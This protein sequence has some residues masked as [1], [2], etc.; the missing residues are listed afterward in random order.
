MNVVV[1][2]GVL[3]RAAEWRALPSGDTL[4]AYEVT[5]RDAEGRARTVPVAWPGGPAE[6][7]LDQGTEVVVAGV[8][9]RRYFRAAGATQ[10]RTEVVAS[11]VV[12]ATDRRRA[13]RLVEAA[14]RALDG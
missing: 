11:G 5:T 2:Q 13:R 7:L 1:L 8:V 12:A 14:R 4:V 3:S 9:Q 6:A 10:S